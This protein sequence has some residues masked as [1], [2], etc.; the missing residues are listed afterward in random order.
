MTGRKTQPALACYCNSRSCVPPKKLLTI[1]QN[2]LTANFI[3]SRIINLP[4]SVYFLF[5]EPFS[6]R[7]TVSQ[8]FILLNGPIC[9]GLFP[10]LL[11]SFPAL[12]LSIK[13][14]QKIL[15]YRKTLQPA[16]SFVSWPHGLPIW[17]QANHIHP[18]VNLDLTWHS[19]FFSSALHYDML[20]GLHVAEIIEILPTTW[21]SVWL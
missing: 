7:C 17:H 16:F 5:L 21:N 11:I 8:S 2:D 3:F 18:S 19:S 4:S 14:F 6:G 12:F 13:R 1:Y 10:W 20:K 9:Y 15:D